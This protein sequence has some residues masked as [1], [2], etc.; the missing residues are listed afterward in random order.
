MQHQITKLSSKD[1]E[2][3]RIHKKE[4]CAARNCLEPAEYRCCGYEGQKLVHEEHYCK[5]HKNEHCKSLDI[6]PCPD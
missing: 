6:H 4:N 2:I 5:Q 1:I 3:L